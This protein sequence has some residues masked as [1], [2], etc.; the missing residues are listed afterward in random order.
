M[1]PY[2]GDQWKYW[3]GGTTISFPFSKAAIREQTRHTLLLQP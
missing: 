1:S 3:Y 2:F